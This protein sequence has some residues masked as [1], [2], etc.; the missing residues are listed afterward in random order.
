MKKI[1][2]KEEDLG[3]R[4]DLVIGLKYKDLSRNKIQTFIKNGDI[5]VNNLKVKTGHILKD[6]DLVTAID[7]GIK[8]EI[9]YK[10]EKVNL[11][12]DIIYEDDDLLVLNK[13]KGLVVHPASTYD[14]ITLVNGLLYQVDKLST[15]N[16]ENRPGIIHRLDKDTSGLLL[17]AKSDLAHK[18]LAKQIA[19]HEIDRNYYAIC[20][21]TFKESTGTI[22][23]PIKRDP[24]DRLKMAV[25]KDG[26]E[27]LTN[28]KV[29]EQYRNHSLLELSLITGRTHQIR[30]HLS[31][32]GHPILG[33]QT[34]GPRKFYGNTGQYL[35]AF[36]LS[37]KHP[38]TKKFM[39]FET[40]MP[41]E[42]LEAIKDIS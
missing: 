10:A 40:K 28:F 27:A 4:L 33:D 16:G 14:G 26:R 7:L 24:K 42:F 39:T 19:N 9:I 30:V 18:R 23:M 8:E 2:I 35:H 31:H 17:V 34:Y 36:R 13:P 11:N 1:D 6:G 25:V 12:L 3:N 15:I 41:D 5:L 38:I 37:F 32:I 22:N 21:G 29:L 20:Y